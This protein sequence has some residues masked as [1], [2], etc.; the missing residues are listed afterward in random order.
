MQA[1]RLSDW[2][3]GHDLRMTN[4]LV[5]TV[6]TTSS[7]CR[8]MF[9]CFAPIRH[10]APGGIPRSLVLSHLFAAAASAVVSSAM[11]SE[12]RFRRRY[13]GLGLDGLHSHSHFIVLCAPS[14][15]LCG[16]DGVGPGISHWSKGPTMCGSM[17]YR[18]PSNW[19]LRPRP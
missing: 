11:V 19:P 18:C 14:V 5:C 16:R 1:P 10:H 4:P 12:M 17:D 15:L 9:S 6:S 13:R 3:Y 8:H 7:H 2:F